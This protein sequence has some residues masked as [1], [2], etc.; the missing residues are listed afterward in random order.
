MRLLYLSARQCWPQNSGGKLRDYHLLSALARAFQ[1]TYLYYAEPGSSTSPPAGFPPCERMIGIPRPPR[2]RPTAVLRGLIGKWPL[3]VLN[4]TSQ[5]MIDAIGAELRAASFDAIH[6][7]SFHMAGCLEPNAAATKAQVF[8]GWHDIASELMQRYSRMPVSLPRKIYARATAGRLVR[9]EAAILNSAGGHIVCSDRE[10]QV[11]LA[12]S[13]GARIEVI[14][15]GVDTSY[16]ADAGEAPGR[17]RIVFVG[18]MHYYANV[19]GVS[20][21]ARDIWPGI[22]KKYPQFRFTV[23][24]ADPGPEVF[25]LRSIPGVEVTGT[26]PDVRPYYRDAFAAVVPLRMGTGTRLK[27]LEAMA[28]GVPVI[29]TALGAEGL[30]VAPGS[31][32]L[33]PGDETEWSGALDSL[34]TPAR[35]ELIQNGRQLAR[36]KYDWEI[37]G[38]K[39]AS[40]YKDWLTSR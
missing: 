38:A 1:V 3:P 36:N 40:V 12:R 35:E 34:F 5:P 39:L 4:Y 25:A 32:I 2:Y 7:D 37:V 21:F 8:Y 14:E 27:I 17:S 29:S 31:N 19:D 11:L 16:F 24:G 6:L 9:A 26:V 33:I 18:A 30:E 10:R 15:N 23:V 20:W 28:A 13:P 22:Y